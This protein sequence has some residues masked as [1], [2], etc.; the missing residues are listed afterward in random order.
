MS[1]VWLCV[2]S[3]ARTG[4]CLHAVN[5]RGAQALR[6]LSPLLCRAC[7]AL[8][9]L[10]LLLLGEQVLHLPVA[11]RR[12]PR[13]PAVWLG[14]LP[15]LFCD[16]T[17]PSPPYPAG[18]AC[19]HLGA[20][21]GR[22]ASGLYLPRHTA[23][24]HRSP[25]FYTTLSAPPTPAYFFLIL[26]CFFPPLSHLSLSF[27]APHSCCKPRHGTCE[28]ALGPPPQNLLIRNTPSQSLCFSPLLGPRSS[29]APRCCLSAGLPVFSFPCLS[30][31]ATSADGFGPGV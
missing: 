3:A 17:A 19:H 9:S 2:S 28:E 29:L 14:L 10:A 1:S 12:S 22:C 26:P 11:P 15:S 7:H 25:F 30:P 21:R 16:S 6:A 20:P 31:R 13:T 27:L 4:S 24:S 23:V 8:A 5:G 18:L